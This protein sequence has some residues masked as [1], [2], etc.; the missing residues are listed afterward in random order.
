MPNRSSEISQIEL[1][2]FSLNELFDV[3]AVVGQHDA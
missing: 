1:H 2:F 3:D